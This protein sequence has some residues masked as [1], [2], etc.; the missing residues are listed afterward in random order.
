MLQKL[1]KSWQQICLAA[2]E[3]GAPSITW[4]RHSV[5]PTCAFASCSVN[6]TS[7]NGFTN[8]AKKGGVEVE[9]ELGVGRGEE[10]SKQGSDMELG[11]KV[12]KGGASAAVGEGVEAKDK[13]ELL[14][15]T[16]SSTVHLLFFLN[17]CVVHHS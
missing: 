8:D 17:W 1:L 7:D 4:V 2:F 10:V 9:E 5:I 16:I 6:S 12:E 11:G 3:S 13:G 15:V 14:T